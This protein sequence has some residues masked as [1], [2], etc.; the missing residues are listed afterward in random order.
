MYS[1]GSS[2][3][4]GHSTTTASLSASATEP[5][6]WVAKCIPVG[7]QDR[8]GLASGYVGMTWNDA[9]DRANQNDA[10]L[11]YVGGGGTCGALPQLAILA[12]HPDHAI[13][14]AFDTEIRPESID[15]FATSKVVFAEQVNP[16]AVWAN[17]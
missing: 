11:V 12:P 16:A 13:V 9:Q 2:Q 7:P 10:Q 5:A 1:V 3:R 14:V 8:L 6:G 17:R 15:G 4:Q